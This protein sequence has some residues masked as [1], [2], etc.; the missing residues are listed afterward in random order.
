MICALTSDWNDSKKQTDGEQRQ[1][2]HMLSTGTVWVH[3]WAQSGHGHGYRHRHGHGHGQRNRHRCAQAQAQAQAGAWLDNTGRGGEGHKRVRAGQ[4]NNR[5]VGTGHCMQIHTCLEDV[6]PQQQC[7][8]IQQR[9]HTCERAGGFILL[10]V[11]A[12]TRADGAA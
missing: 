5:K 1:Y 2:R 6:S 9:A 11:L 8:L 10:S 3:A 4:Q 7:H 12:L